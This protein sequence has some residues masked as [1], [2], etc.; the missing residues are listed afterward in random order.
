MDLYNALY[1]QKYLNAGPL[2][3]HAYPVF[4]ER[5]NQKPMIIIMQQSN[6]AASGQIFFTKGTKKSIIKTQ[7]AADLKNRDE[8]IQSVKE[9][10]DKREQLKTPFVSILK[11][12]NG[13]NHIRNASRRLEDL[14]SFCL[15]R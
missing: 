15:I 5:K 3:D 9:E 13:L 2:L 1:D 10:L 4:L 8:K 11:Q 6:T 14:R 12:K 7:I